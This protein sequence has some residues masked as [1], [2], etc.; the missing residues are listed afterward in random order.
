[1]IQSESIESG[2]FPGIS[3]QIY[4]DSD[5]QKLR[6]I[7][8]QTAGISLSRNKSTFV[9]SRLAPL[10]RG[11]DSQTFSR[12][13]NRLMSNESELRKAI[14]VLTVNHS[15]FNREKHHF[16]HL[17][18]KVRP[19]LLAKA[20]SGEP[21]RLWSAGCSN[22]EEVYSLAMW[23]LGPNRNEADIFLNADVKILATDIADQ[24][25]TTASDACYPTD[26]LGNMPSDLLRLW[27]KEDGGQTFVSDEI[28][29]M[30]HVRR[31]NL[32]EKWPFNR[33]FDVIFC[34]NVVI[35]FDEQTTARLMK[36][37]SQTLVSGGHLYIGH[38][39]TIGREAKAYLS[40]IGETIYR[41]KS[42]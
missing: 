35:Y 11:S 25:L 23:L 3:E 1:M 8:R 21:V 13:I 4:S 22:G 14:N 12:Y 18:A 40:S 32:I 42:A 30:V 6:A 24:V 38:S 26:S 10:V 20:R 28:K 5:F 37:F 27:T 34:R 39:E 17:V 2:P 7:V 9:Y 19:A 31:L 36:R 16:E 33:Q 29:K 41:K 15:F